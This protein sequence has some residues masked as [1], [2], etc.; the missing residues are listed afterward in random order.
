TGRLFNA[1]SGMLTWISLIG[2]TGSSSIT[3]GRMITA[4]SASAAAPTNRRRDRF[5]NSRSSL[6]DTRHI[7]PRRHDDGHHFSARHEGTEVHNSITLARIFPPG[8][9]GLGRVFK[10]SNLPFRTR[11]APPLSQC[12][13][14]Q[15]PRPGQTG[16]IPFVDSLPCPPDN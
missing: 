11:P 12:F 1:R 16:E 4:S 8:T 5:L 10:A 7:R 9:I 3:I 15:P 14:A 6:S 13:R 2:A